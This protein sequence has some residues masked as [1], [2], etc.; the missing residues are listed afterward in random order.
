MKFILFISLSFNFLTVQAQE[1]FT[2]K[3]APEKI[4]KMYYEALSYTP[5]NFIKAKQIL[6]KTIKSA[7][8]FIDAYVLLANIYEEEQDYKKAK[9][10]YLTAI[11][12]DS[13]YTKEV[14]LIVAEN[15]IKAEE[16]GNAIIYL[17]KYL[18][19]TGIL[20]SNRLKAESYLGMC[21][22]AKTAKANPV[23]FSPI[24]LGANINTSYPEYLPAITA[25]EK[26]LIFT[27]QRN[28]GKGLNEDFYISH[29]T[30]SGWTMA[31]NLGKPINTSENE[32]AQTI[33]P[34]GKY[35]YFTGCNRKD[36]LGSC[37]IYY[38]RKTG[39]SW[40]EPLNIGPPINTSRWESQPSI[41]ADGRS[42]YFCTN[43]PG[44]RGGK[45]IWVSH[46]EKD[47]IWGEPINL[48]ENIN[49]IKDDQCPFI[50]PDNQTL[51]FSSDGHLGMGDADLFFSKKNKSGEWNIAINLGYPINTNK[52]ESSMIVS[53]D[54]HHA[55]F[56]SDRLAT[57]GALDLYY[58]D[59]Y[60][61]AR[62]IPVTYVKATIKDAE[63]N[64][65][66]SAKVELIDLSS[67]I[68]I[69][70]SSSDVVNGDF[71]ACLV[72][73][74]EYAL[75]VSKNGYLFH[76]ENFSLEQTK[77]NEPY[78]LEIPLQPIRA[79]K[80]VIL[81]NIFYES[82]SYTLKDASK[83]ELDK[84]IEFLATY[85]AIIIQ[86]NGHTDNVGEA[87]FNLKLSTNRAKA[88]YEYLVGRGVAQ[89]RIRFKGFGAEK[90][91][92]NNETEKGRALNRRTEFEIVA[93]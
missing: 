90:P 29:Q 46:R 61:E 47:E 9:E 38:S 56:A 62:P 68:V 27:S 55:Y 6:D 48:G 43:R 92:S 24:N 44:G 26:T 86:I 60:K 57:Y 53:A 5:G 32:G 69:L 17:K 11:E 22:F 1:V 8:G 35:I 18:N 73:G 74:K 51:Y 72:S 85:P 75:N 39:N 83:I 65:K 89:N 70:E 20:Y 25:D 40:S 63:T 30:D 93:N 21:E 16:Y 77:D 36:G 76:S 2:K 10:N 33:S 91:I 3:N 23:P 78:I 42:L 28:T 4:L 54:G 19:K 59:L 81:K 7:P 49:T 50:H 52:N 31:T 45:D 41:S 15:E 79:G 67:R 12:L 64:Q 66:L 58:F 34:D 88:V 13:I 80:R 14:V 84:L 82:G 87:S 37:D 71:L